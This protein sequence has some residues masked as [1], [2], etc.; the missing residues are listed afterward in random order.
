MIL[1]SDLRIIYLHNL[2]LRSSVSTT[3]NSCDLYN[4]NTNANTM[5]SEYRTEYLSETLIDKP[6]N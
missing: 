2:I 5:A 3:V 4:A 6:F 1:H